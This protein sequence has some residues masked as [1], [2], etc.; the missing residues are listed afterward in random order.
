[1]ENYKNSRKKYVVNLD[2]PDDGKSNRT[3]ELN[4]SKKGMVTPKPKESSTGEVEKTENIF[5]RGFFG[6]Y[7]IKWVIR[8]LVKIYSSESSFFSKKR[9]ESSVA[10]VIGQIG[11]VLFLYAHYSTLTIS[12][13]LLWASAE[14]VISGYYVTQI[15]RE[16]KDHINDDTVIEITPEYYEDLPD[17][18]GE[19][20]DDGDLPKNL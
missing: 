17:Y 5:I 2:L 4:F 11:M 8:E 15:Q 18:S 13:F 1:M 3:I 7:N 19:V 6:W 16:K 14:F 12:E 9:V 20:E 10:F